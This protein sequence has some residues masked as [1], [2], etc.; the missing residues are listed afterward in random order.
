MSGIN[1]LPWREWRRERARRVFFAHLGLMIAAAMSA[2]L[3]LGWHFDREL[4]RL[5]RR[6]DYLRERILELDRCIAESGSLTEQTEGVLSRL[7]TARSL[8]GNRHAM[9]RTLDAL[10]RTAA[11]G[12]HYTSVSMVGDLLT[13]SGSA[14]SNDRVSALMRNM[15][16]S[17]WLADPSLK[18]ISETREGPHYGGRSSKFEL[19]FRRSDGD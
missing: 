15:E 3:A 17:R 10:A 18:S 1:L 4:D 11:H 16:D 13:A 8:Q 7:E 2:T 12:V 9:V 6:S 19:T 14:A 5:D